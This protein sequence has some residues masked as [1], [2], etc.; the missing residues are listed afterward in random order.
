M[1]AI[2]GGIWHGVKGARNSP[3]V[4]ILR[5]PLVLLGDLHI[6]ARTQG[7]RLTGA[8]STIKARAPVTGGNFGVWGTRASYTSSSASAQC[9]YDRRHVFY[10]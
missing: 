2:G 1:G 3:R 4:C 10:I 6:V 5:S 9:L 7:E 8:L